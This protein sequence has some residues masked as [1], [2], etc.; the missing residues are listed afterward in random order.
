MGNFR[1][2]TRWIWFLRGTSVEKDIYVSASQVRKFKLR[3]EDRVVG[4]VRE[5]SGDEKIMLLKK[6]Y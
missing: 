2:F 1:S 5:P 4:E 6:F 3:T